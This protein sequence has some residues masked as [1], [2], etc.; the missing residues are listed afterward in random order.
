MPFWR[1]GSNGN[2]VDLPKPTIRGSNAKGR[3]G[4]QDFVHVAAIDVY[5]CP[6]GEQLQDGR[7]PRLCVQS[8]WGDAATKLNKI[9]NSTE[10]T[11]PRTSMIR[12]PPAF[13]GC[14]SPGKPANANF[15]SRPTSWSN[16]ERPILFR[17]AQLAEFCE[18]PID[19]VTMICRRLIVSILPRRRRSKLCCLPARY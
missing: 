2:Q 7:Q 11:R 4:K 16:F 19:L 8:G 15:E 3:L 18:M 6:A 13:H 9:R 10:I 1:G 14:M 12:P 5:L 17:T